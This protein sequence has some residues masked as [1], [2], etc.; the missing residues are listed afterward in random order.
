[1]ARTPL[2]LDRSRWIDDGLTPPRPRHMPNRT[3]EGDIESRPDVDVD[4]GPIVL[5]YALRDRLAAKK[6]GR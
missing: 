1:M 3:P 2:N 4:G 5:Y 6:E